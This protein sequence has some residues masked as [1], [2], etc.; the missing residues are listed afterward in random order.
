MVNAQ[1]I[2]LISATISDYSAIH[3]MAEYYAHALSQNCESISKRYFL[4]NFD[5]R[6]YI[7][8]PDRY[9]YLVKVNDEIAGFM[10]IH[11]SGIL[12]ETQWVMGEFFILTEFQNQG[13]GYSVAHQIWNIHQG[14]WEV[15][16]IPE[17]K[18]AYFFW[19]KVIKAHTNGHYLE[20]I[21]DINYDDHQPKRI[22]FTFDSSI[23]KLLN[24]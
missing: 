23:K 18:A 17:N 9:A 7:T 24:K 20:E 8:N 2:H 21:K 6:N 3:Q 10:L 14:I 13:I 15:S 11:Q 5:F 16:I 22:V 19:K 12:S 4:H 1:V